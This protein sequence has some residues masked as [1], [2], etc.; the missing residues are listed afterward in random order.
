MDDRLV[1]V[2]ARSLADLLDLAWR[3]SEDPGLE[4]RLRDALNGAAT[5]VE[6]DLYAPA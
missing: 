6:A 4:I 3:A 2:S 1:M 5:Q